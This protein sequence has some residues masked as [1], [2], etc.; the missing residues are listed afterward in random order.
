MAL[1]LKHVPNTP[2][3]YKFFSK[4]K[5]IYIGK[6]KDLKKTTIHIKKVLKNIFKKIKILQIQ[7]Y[8]PPGTMLARF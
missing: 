1:D 4:N 7:V 8:P 3:I 6:A 2:G 5:I